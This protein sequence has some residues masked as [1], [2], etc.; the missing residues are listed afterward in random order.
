[1]ITKM[2]SLSRNDGVIRVYGSNGDKH[3]YE[4]TYSGSVWNKVDLGSGGD[5]MQNVVLGN[6]RNDGTM[7]VYGANND[8]HIYEFTY[9]HSLPILSFTGEANYVSDGIDPEV[10]S[11]KTT[12]VNRVTY[13]NA[14]NGA[15]QTGYPKGHIL[16]SGSE[17]SGSP[18]TM[19]YISGAYN[20]GAIY[21]SSTTLAPGNDYT[22]YFEA[23]DIWG[24]TATGAPTSPISGP[25]IISSAT[26]NWTGE[27]NYVTSGLY[28]ITGSPTTTFAYRVAYTD[29]NN[30]LAK[31]G[32][33]NVVSLK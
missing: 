1:M 8:D 33:P 29:I 15:P 20:T 11:P 16:K 27:P 2:A 22:Y 13:T 24:A 28:P 30:E 19:N 7:R 32:Y 18:F 17:I 9:N 4:F 21:A 10:G 6:G 14:D 5:T 23:Y 26:L 12:F 3:I 31:T 25:V